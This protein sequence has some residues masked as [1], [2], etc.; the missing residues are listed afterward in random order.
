VVIDAVTDCT[1]LDESPV[2][3]TREAWRG[4]RE[5][6]AMRGNSSLAISGCICQLVLR[7]QWAVLIGKTAGWL[8]SLP[9]Q[10]GKRLFH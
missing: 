1:D 5:R 2:A 4:L 10:R 6:G 3:E 8:S 9:E 7:M